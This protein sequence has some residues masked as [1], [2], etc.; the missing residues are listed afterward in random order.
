MAVGKGQQAVRYL[1]K[2]TLEGLDVSITE[3][4]E[5][6][7]R[8]IHSQV[9]GKAWVAPKTNISTKDDRFMMATLAAAD[10]PPFMAVKALMVNPA[11][12]RRNLSAINSS[13]TLLDS[14]SGLPVAAMDGN[15]VTALR[16]AGASAVVAKRMANE[17]S[18]VLALIGCGVQARSHLAAYAE[19]YPLTEVRAYGRG[20]RSRDALCQLVTHLGLNAVASDT[21][22]DAVTDADL[23]VSSI[24]LL[25][26]VEPF[27]NA[28]WLK[29]GAF[30][31]STDFALPW[32]PGSLSVFDRIIIDD[33][34]QEATMAV[35][36]LDAALVDGD[37]GE[38]V[39][40]KVR[41]RSDKLERTAFVFRSVALG[42]L[43]IA[44]LAYKKAATGPVT[45]N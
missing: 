22:K 2:E 8:L 10:D 19:L 33:R 31:S 35:P 26:R 23:V 30:V 43:A 3:V 1:S 6:M 17:D 9:Q 36:M 38:L 12:P 28:N 16:T 14:C 4:V 18:S 15:W 13:I 44:A 27:L 39:S 11:N 25:P 29:P 21:A 24:P 32:M 5:S 37:I 45:I 40:G 7:E 34:K 41:G 20:S 42:D